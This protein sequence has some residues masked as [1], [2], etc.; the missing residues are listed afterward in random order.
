VRCSHRHVTRETPGDDSVLICDCC[1]LGLVAWD[2]STRQ[3][4]AEELALL[5]RIANA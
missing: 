1:G 4:L 2:N 5:N 3:E